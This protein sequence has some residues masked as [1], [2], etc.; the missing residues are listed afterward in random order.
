MKYCLRRITWYG[1]R[2]WRVMWIRP[3]VWSCFLLAANSKMNK[4]TIPRNKLSAILL[5]AELAFLMKSAFESEVGGVIY[6]TDS[7]ISFSWC[8]NQSIKLRLRKLIKKDYLRLYKMSFNG[9]ETP[10]TQIRKPSRSQ[11]RSWSMLKKT[12]FGLGWVNQFRRG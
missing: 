8:S 9:E 4:E 10:G 7:T 3:G 12:T 11:D 1:K 2:F 6:D 5:C